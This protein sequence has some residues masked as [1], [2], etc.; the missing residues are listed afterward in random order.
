MSVPVR[1][2]TLGLVLGGALPEA[3]HRLPLP[4]KGAIRAL[5][6]S[7]TP[8]LPISTVSTSGPPSPVS[9]TRPS[10]PLTRLASMPTATAAAAS[11]SGG[12]PP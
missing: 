6:R 12:C 3:P 5:P 2:L 7:A 10:A 11:T 8:P 4:R 1:R 9:T